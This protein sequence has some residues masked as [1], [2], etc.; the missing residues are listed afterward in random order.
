MAG[1]K[2]GQGPPPWLPQHS[3]LRDDVSVRQRHTL[4]AAD[5]DGAEDVTEAAPQVPPADGQQGTPLQRPAQRLDLWHKGKKGRRR[6]GRKL[7][8]VTPEPVSLATSHLATSL[9]KK[10]QLLPSSCS[11]H[12]A[13]TTK[14]PWLQ[15]CQREAVTPLCWVWYQGLVRDYSSCKHI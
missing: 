10:S 15:L 8:A 13:P 12:S 2:V 7:L 4:H 1:D 3:L 9:L 11:P 5:P 14:V 6:T